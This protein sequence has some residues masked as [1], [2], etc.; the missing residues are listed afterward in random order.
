MG[1]HAKGTPVAPRRFELGIRCKLRRTLTTR[2]NL[3]GLPNP[4]IYKL[5]FCNPRWEN[6]MRMT[7]MSK[8][9]KEGRQVTILEVYEKN[10]QKKDG[11]EVHSV[12]QSIGP[13]LSN[14]ETSK[15]WAET[16]GTKQ[17][18]KS[19]LETST[20]KQPCSDS[21]HGEVEDEDYTDDDDEQVVCELILC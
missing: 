10:H 20:G 21:T 9:K 14:E 3:L 8:S 12:S 5:C 7:F 2:P 4:T 19:V 1:N 16:V 17:T 11:G 6:Y 18:G 15:L 13:N